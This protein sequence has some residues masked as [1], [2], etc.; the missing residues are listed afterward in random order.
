MFG[1]RGEGRTE[2]NTHEIPRT[3][4]CLILNVRDSEGFLRVCAVLLL[5]LANYSWRGNKG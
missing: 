1:D 5:L 2:E 3:K 4:D